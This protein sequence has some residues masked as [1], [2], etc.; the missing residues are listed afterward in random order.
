M[1]SQPGSYS[2]FYEKSKVGLV[3]AKLQNRAVH[4]L[5]RVMLLKPPEIQHVEIQRTYAHE[6][7]WRFEP[8]SGS[9][10]F[11]SVAACVNYILLFVI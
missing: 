10:R 4:H 2:H 11:T 1:Q 6:C 8:S 7:A 9:E 5:I 3:E